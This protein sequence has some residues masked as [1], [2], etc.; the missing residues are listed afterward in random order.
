MSEGDAVQLL[1]ERGLQV[2]AQRL[3]VLRAVSE[4]PHG[5]A[6]DIDGRRP[7]RDRCDLPPGRLRRARRPHRQGASS[8]A[9]SRPGRRPATRTGSATT[10]TTS[11]A[12]RCGRMVDVDC[13]VGDTPCLTAVRR[14]RLR[15]R[16]GRGHLLGPLPRRARRRPMPRRTPRPRTNQTAATQE[17]PTCPTSENPAI[18]AP[19]PQGGAGPDEPGLVAE[20]ARP[21]GPAP[22]LARS[23][24]LGED[25]DYAEEFETLDVEAAQARR[26]RGDDHL[27]GLVAGRL[28]PLRPALHPHVLARGRHLPHRGRPRR[29]RRR[30]ASASPRST[31]G[32]TTPTSTRPAGCSGRSSRSTASKLSWADLLVL[33]G[34]VRA[35]VD[36]L[37][38]L[39][40]RLRPRGHLGA[41]GD[42]LGP[43]GQVA[44]RRALQRAT[45]S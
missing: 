1:R 26:R 4:R 10:T 39:R 43:R 29:R 20:P 44:R 45:A 23:N 12:A 14:R 31:A 17:R 6:D 27:A 38:D 42:L 34:N 36:G 37:R 13:A 40:L 25:F 16:R 18:D 21:V 15:D 5:T 32:P 30:R 41:R 35:R 3:A 2:T 8:G 19:D 22:A 24:P 9:S 11:S 33:A 7:G 28:R